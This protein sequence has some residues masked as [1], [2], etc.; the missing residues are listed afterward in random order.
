MDGG[1]EFTYEGQWRY[2]WE[3]S[4]SFVKNAFT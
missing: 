2:L 1:F 3:F 4:Q